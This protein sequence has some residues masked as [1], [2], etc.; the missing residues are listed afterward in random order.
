MV[1]TNMA[2]DGKL[3]TFLRWKY[4]GEVT[5]LGLHSMQWDRHWSR[6]PDQ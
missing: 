2:E 5:G 1:M 6:D 3:T 4:P